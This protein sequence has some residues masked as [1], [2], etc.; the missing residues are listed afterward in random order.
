[1]EDIITGDAPSGYNSNYD[2]D[3]ICSEERYNG[4]N[5]F[6]GASWMSEA[7]TKKILAEYHKSKEKKAETTLGNE[8]QDS[9][10]TQYYNFFGGSHEDQD[11]HQ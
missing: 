4:Y 5:P 6:E 8:T 10:L 11:Y 1:M 3:E 7:A 9:I 2:I